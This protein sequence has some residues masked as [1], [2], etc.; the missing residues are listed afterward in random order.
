MARVTLVFAVLLAGLGLGAYLGTGSLNSTAL[1][2]VG[3][4]V[5]LGGFGALALGPDEGRRRLFM[6]LNVTI[7]L[8]GFAGT[9]VEIFRGLTS[10]KEVDLTAL[11]AQLVLAWLLLIYVI[12]CVRSFLA[13]RPSGVIAMRREKE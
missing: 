1:I 13:A 7:A 4:G 2:P 8:L 11:A 3:F 10:A 9:I 6:H 12:L 5:V